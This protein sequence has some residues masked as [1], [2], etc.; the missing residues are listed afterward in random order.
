MQREEKKVSVHMD[1]CEQDGG[2]GANAGSLATP[3]WVRNR[4]I[5]LLDQISEGFEDKGSLY[6]SESQA[7][8][9]TI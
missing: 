3:L 5:Y 9:I 6:A 1:S 2:Q 4:V 7:L 8:E